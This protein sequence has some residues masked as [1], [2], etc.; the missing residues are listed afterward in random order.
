ML[1]S[2]LKEQILIKNYIKGIEIVFYM[3]LGAGICLA[4]VRN[5][6]MTVFLS[7]AFYR[8]FIIAIC[9]SIIFNICIDVILVLLTKV[10]KVK[11]TSEKL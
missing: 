10:I 1:M 7:F 8:S 6:F 3:F 2:D 4:K 9:L 11:N 5:D